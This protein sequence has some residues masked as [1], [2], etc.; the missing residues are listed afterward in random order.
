MYPRNQNKRG[1]NR[2]PARIRGKPNGVIRRDHPNH[3]LK[4][5]DRNPKQKRGKSESPRRM[6]QKVPL[7]IENR[8]S[9]YSERKLC[10]SVESVANHAE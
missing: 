3:S 2:V 10:K 4:N 5:R 6:K 9:L 7:L 8:Q 1:Q